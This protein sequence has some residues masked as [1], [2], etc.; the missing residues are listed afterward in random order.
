MTLRYG[1]DQVYKGFQVFDRILKYFFSV[2]FSCF[3]LAFF[4]F[5]PA[6]PLVA[7]W[8]PSEN[9]KKNGRL[10]KALNSMT[11]F[12]CRILRVSSSFKTQ[13]FRFAGESLRDSS[14]FKTEVPFCSRVLAKAF[15]PNFT[16]FATEFLSDSSSF[17]TQL[18]RFA[19]EL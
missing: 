16:G 9:Q 15:K 19:A 14:S 3:F 13:K 8:R 18:H 2:F 5:S 12:C 10:I 6:R 17:K 4:F 1:V 7:G 11:S